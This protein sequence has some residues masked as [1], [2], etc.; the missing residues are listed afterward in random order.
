MC[1][2]LFDFAKSKK[3][4]CIKLPK[5]IGFITIFSSKKIFDGWSIL[6]RSYLS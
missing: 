4:S 1:T 2:I 6:F 5:I 3:L